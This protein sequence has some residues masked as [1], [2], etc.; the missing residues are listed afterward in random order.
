MKK[1]LLVLALAGAAFGAWTL[2]L[3][4]PMAAPEWSAAE[5]RIIDSLWLAR[6]P[7]LAPDPSN[8]VADDPEAARFGHAL[9]FD[10]RLSANGGIACSTCHQPLR[11]F[12]DGLPKGVAIGVSRRN[13]PSIVGTAH[14]A[15]F[16]WDGRKD[17][18]WSQALSPLEDPAE[19][20]SNRM[21]IVR[22]VSGDEVY[23][24][25]YEALFGPLPDVSDAQ[26]F[27]SAAAPGIGP[28]LD[29][30]W[31]SMTQADRNTV[32][33]VFANLGKA[34]AAYERRLLHGLAPFDA[35]ADAVVA[36][37]TARQAA[38]FSNDEAHGLRLFI[39]KARCTECHNGPLFTN[40]EFH[41]TGTFAYP[42]ELPDR[43]RADG[44][45]EVR[46]DPF[47]CLGDY[48]DD[49]D[50]YCGELRFARTGIELIGAVKTP[51]LRN[52]HNT[53][54]FM[55]RG[56]VA[57]LAEAL[58]HYNDAPLAMIGHNEAE[59]PLGLNRRELKQ[60]EEFLLTLPAPVAASP[61]WLAAPQRAQSSGSGR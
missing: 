31:Q 40:G 5:I 58:E 55:H 20:G 39:G 59:F 50:P 15:W 34:L 61:E 52:L 7:E 14:G 46:A 49:P 21:Q 42:G 41:N 44:L 30:A 11:N 36:G 33:R 9:F 6:Q 60:L 35:Y 13:T 53:A 24:R 43:G 19:H 4:R 45:R 47:N 8:A 28:G 12:A 48:N 37:D 18:Q 1:L 57:T 29:K 23:R 38:V 32:N 26:R 56:Q 27:P 2:W 17:S 25:Q 10:P 51:S 54:P 16:Y 3:L 22:L